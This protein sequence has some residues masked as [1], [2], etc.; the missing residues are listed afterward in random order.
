M[1]SDIV[2]AIGLHGEII[3]NNSGIDVTN[4]STDDSSAESTNSYRCTNGSRC[5]GTNNSYICTNK[6]NCDGSSNTL[7]CQGG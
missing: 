4:A 3:N 5:F 6:S 7:A 1:K 2:V